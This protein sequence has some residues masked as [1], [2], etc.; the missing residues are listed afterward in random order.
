VVSFKR[1]SIAKDLN[2]YA[3]YIQTTMPVPTFPSD[4]PR[5]DNE[6]KRDPRTPAEIIRDIIGSVQTHPV[7][8]LNETNVQ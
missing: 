7:S 3:E 1:V 8:V 6:H 4:E 2:T 5:Q